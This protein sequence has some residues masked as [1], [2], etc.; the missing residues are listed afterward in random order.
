MPADLI[1][2]IFPKKQPLSANVDTGVRKDATQTP[3]R[4]GADSAFIKFILGF[5]PCCKQHLLE[6]QAELWAGSSAG[7]W[8]TAQKM[9]ETR[10]IKVVF[11][12]SHWDLISL[13]C[14]LLLML[15]DVLEEFPAILSA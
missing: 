12:F 1:M 10:K 6:N 14:S 4:I 13:R 9:P 8:L 3:E 15:F 7:V 5:R 11:R 2:Q